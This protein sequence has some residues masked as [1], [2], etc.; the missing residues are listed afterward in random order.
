L[1][2]NISVSMEIDER[3]AVNAVRGAEIAAHR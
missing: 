2:E 1:Q 3:E